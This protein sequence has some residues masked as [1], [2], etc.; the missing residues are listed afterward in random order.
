MDL[1]IDYSAL[2]SVSAQVLSQGGEFSSLLE[3]ISKVN[4]ELQTYWEGADATKYTG[5]V[6]T[7]AQSMK[8]LAET[9]NEIGAFLKRVGDAYEA[10]CRANADAING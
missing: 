7:Q 6:A 1:K 4:T 2:G 3:T 9:I 5:A 10:A 8:K